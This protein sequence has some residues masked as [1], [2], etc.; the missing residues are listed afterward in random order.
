MS[1]KDCSLA[2]ADYFSVRI[3]SCASSFH[4][5]ISASA[6]FEELICAP[7][8]GGRL[9]RRA[10]SAPRPEAVAGNFAAH[11]ATREEHRLAKARI[12]SGAAMGC[13]P[14]LDGRPSAIRFRNL[15]LGAA[16]LSARSSA[17]RRNCEPWRGCSCTP[18]PNSTESQ[19]FSDRN[20]GPGC[21]VG[22]VV[23]HTSFPRR[24][25]T[26]Q[27]HACA[28]TGSDAQGWGL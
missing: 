2:K 1:R 20:L 9:G 5:R 18:R 19:A 22:V 7:L 16:W 24:L 15:G 10:T 13:R 25:D 11:G 17:G 28:R 21:L 8:N 23:V 3:H 12:A 6:G 4:S 14:A 26:R 27:L